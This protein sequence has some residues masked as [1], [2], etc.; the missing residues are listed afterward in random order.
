VLG[1][2]WGVPPILDLKA[3]RA[4][5]D[6]LQ[7]LAAEGLLESARDVAEGG[8]AVAAAKIGFPKDLGVDIELISAGLPAEC[9]LFGEDAS[10]VLVTCDPIK[11]RTIEGIAVKYGLNAQCIGFTTSGKFAIRIDGIPVIEDEVSTLK[12]SWRQ[13]L[14]QAL[15]GGPVPAASL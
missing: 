2:L 8:I 1:E 6:L 3:E 7:A 10:R 14:E 5:Q 12:Q 15:Q 9:V 4:L 13:A 11:V